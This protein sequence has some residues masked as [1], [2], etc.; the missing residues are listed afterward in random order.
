MHPKQ[1]PLIQATDLLQLFKSPD[2]VLIDATNG[3][4]SRENYTQKHLTTLRLMKIIWKAAV[5]IMS[6]KK[7]RMKKRL[8]ILKK[9][10]P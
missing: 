7:K 5:I 3:K 9:L 1:A 6:I 8:N 10:L 4:N 2:L